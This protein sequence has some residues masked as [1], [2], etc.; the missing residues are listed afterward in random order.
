MNTTVGYH[1]SS[2]EHGCFVLELVASSDLLP[3]IDYRHSW[4]QIMSADGS[5]IVYSMILR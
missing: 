2:I 4:Q 3:S 5:R 1:I